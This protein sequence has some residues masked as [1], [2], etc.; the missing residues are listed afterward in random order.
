MNKYILEYH[1]GDDY[2]IVFFDNFIELYG[3][4]EAFESLGSKLRKTPY[5]C[6]DGTS[7]CYSYY[8]PPISD[9]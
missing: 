9:V 4:Y 3:A 5:Y 1:I 7:F 6:Y 8:D 2:H